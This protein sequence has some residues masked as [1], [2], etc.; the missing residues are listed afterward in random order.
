VIPIAVGVD[1]FIGQTAYGVEDLPIQGAE[2][3]AQKWVSLVSKKRNL[4]ITCINPRTKKVT[5]VNLLEKN[6][7][8]ITCR[9]LPAV[10]SDMPYSLSRRSYGYGTRRPFLEVEVVALTEKI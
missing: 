1:R 2:A 8:A 10:A 3:V 4:A 9:T 6:N 5:E 7:V